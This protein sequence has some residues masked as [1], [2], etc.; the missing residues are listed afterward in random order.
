MQQIPM[1]ESEY[2]MKRRAPKHKVNVAK[3]P[4][5]VANPSYATP[6][7]DVV[8][9]CEEERLFDDA[10]QLLKDNTYP[11]TFVAAPDGFVSLMVD[12]D[13]LE[14]V[15]YV[16]GERYEG[17]FDELTQDE[18]IPV[19][20]EIT[21]TVTA[22]DLGRETVA[23]YNPAAQLKAVFENDPASAP[24]HRRVLELCAGAEGLSRQDLEA[25][26]KAEDLIPHDPRTGLVSIFPTYYIDNLE[27]AGGLVWKN[28][29]FA[30]EEG[31]SIL[32]EIQ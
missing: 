21:Y 2:Q 24:V 19:E 16:D 15:I 4:I 18:S 6:A 8:T 3:S 12:N 5:L 20:A 10:V 31:R 28:A 14:M 13:F 30:T 25:A 7:Y 23:P 27:K 1:R 22:T 9:F 11:K 17:T 26:L 29:W 32:A